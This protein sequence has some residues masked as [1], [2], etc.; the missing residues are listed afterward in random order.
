[1]CSVLREHRHLLLNVM[2]MFLLDP[3]EDWKT[4]VADR[5]DR[6]ATTIESYVKMRLDYVRRKLDLHNPAGAEAASDA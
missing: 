6:R 4:Y 5:R 2:E 3:V 1:M